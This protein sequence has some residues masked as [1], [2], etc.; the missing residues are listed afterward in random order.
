[1]RLR[2][3][4]VHVEALHLRIKGAPDS[5]SLLF[6]LDEIYPAVCVHLI[7]INQRKRERSLLVRWIY[8]PTVRPFLLMLPSSF[9]RC[10]DICYRKLLRENVV[11]AI[12]S[13]WFKGA[14]SMLSVIFIKEQGVPEVVLDGQNGFIHA[15]LGG[16]VRFNLLY[17]INDRFLN[18]QLLL[19]RQFAPCEV[20]DAR[21]LL[22]WV[23]ALFGVSFILINN[24]SIRL[25]II[26]KVLIEASILL[27]AVLRL[28][29]VELDSVSLHLQRKVDH[30]TPLCWSVP[31]LW[32]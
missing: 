17:F 9:L 26:S 2:L 25:I 3:G 15:L 7:L 27:L 23:D 1:M 13:H 8:V 11:T 5:W 19:E 12:N 32:H 10:K 6:S 4:R 20:I 24:R 21:P 22:A 30:Q 16:L 28:V 29:G 14:Q 18:G 31:A